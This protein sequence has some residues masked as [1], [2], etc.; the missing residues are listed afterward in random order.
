M[1]DG[2]KRDGDGIGESRGSTETQGSIDY[3]P[4]Y[5]PLWNNLITQ[6]G[7]L[8]AA[9]ALLGL[10]TFMLFSVLAP[11]DNPYVDVVGFLVIPSILVIGLTLV[12]LGIYFKSWRARRKDPNLELRFRL[13]RIDLNVPAQKRVAKVFAGLTFALLPIL[14]VSGYHVYHYTDSVD[15]CGT[16]CHGVMTPQMTAFERSPHARVSCAECHIGAGAGWFVKA[17]LSGTRQV[18]AVMRDSYPRPIPSAISALRPARETCETCHWPKKFFGAQLHEIVRY[19]SDEGN[20]QRRIDMLVKTGGGDEAFGTAEGIHKHMALD[21]A[22]EYIATDEDL[23]EIP[24]V[25]WTKPNGEELVYRSDGK[26]SS[27][28]QPEGEHR[29]IDCMDCHNRPAHNFAAPQ[30][31]VD[32]AMYSGRIDQDI[33]YIKRESINALLAPAE[34]KEA[35]SEAIG[36]YL[37]GF[38]EAEY[39]E[40]FASNRD[41]VYRAIDAVRDVYE[42]NFFPEMKV[43]WRTYPDN[44]G[45]LISNGC[46]RCHAGDHVDQY[47]N[48]ISNDCSACHTFL[49]PTD[50]RA[51]TLLSRGDFE[52]PYALGPNHDAI[53]CSSCHTGGLSPQ[54]SCEGCHVEQ[55]SLYTAT[56]DYLDDMDIDLDP[57]PML[58]VATC[59]DCHD[60]SVAHDIQL[61]ANSCSDCH[62]DVEYAEMLFEWVDDVSASE[63]EAKAVMEELEGQLKSAP[64]S[65]EHPDAVAWLEKSK[66]ILER[67]NTAGAQHNPDL[68]IA[69]YDAI[70]E[71]GR[72]IMA[73]FASR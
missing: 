38:Y 55:Q 23:Q 39:P 30:K 27:D 68:A 40:Y 22:I 17:K 24:W 43:D 4:Q 46:F 45:H 62:D 31:A 32:V 36:D 65:T 5:R 47:G 10:V 9:L 72:T 48:T 67:L 16:A 51:S 33:P 20:T 3:K 41:V 44:I 8:I 7:M 58:D 57:N 19:S 13:P 18:V 71:Q 42:H 15:F 34:S 63:S 54:P 2:D 6:A 66:T 53:G 25:K 11:R 56:V 26:P 50:D 29:T 69:A 35:A 49:T 14:A 70:A 60:A 59:V 28:P 52:H 37:T 1:A 21:G 64:V 12:P 61:V 73:G